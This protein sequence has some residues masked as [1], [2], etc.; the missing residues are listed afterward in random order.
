MRWEETECTIELWFI[1]VPC[2]VDARL[3]CIPYVAEIASV[4]L[5]QFVELR[6]VFT[7]EKI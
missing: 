5:L 1:S 3:C 7:Y 2:N 6:G 4:L